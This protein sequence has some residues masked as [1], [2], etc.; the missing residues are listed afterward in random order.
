MTL[1]D[2]TYFVG[3]LSLPAIRENSG[4]TGSEA[5][6]EKIKNKEL[7]AMI[8]KYERRFLKLMLGEK[9]T[10]EFYSG[11]NL[12][13]TDP[14]KEKWIV[15]KNKLCI[16]GELLKKSPIA[17]YVYRFYL[18][19]LRDETTQTGTK[20]S[21]STFADNVSDTR[22][23]VRSW[24]EM[25]DFNK[26]FIKWFEDNFDT[27]KPYWNNHVIESDLFTHINEMNL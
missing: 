23:L 11:L 10:N 1:I 18:L 24:N 21:K 16:E 22:K 27:Y 15:L 14:N 7:N 19:K 3:E 13:D 6:L 5:I 12:P 20:K 17:N 25:V 2:S 9:F 8:E 26:K 4:K